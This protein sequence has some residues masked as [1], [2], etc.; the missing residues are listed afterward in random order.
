MQYPGEDKALGAGKAWLFLVPDQMTYMTMMD[1][2]LWFVHIIDSLVRQT[3]FDSLKVH[4]LGPASP[5]SEP[6][7]MH[8]LALKTPAARTN[9]F[10]QTHYTFVPPFL[11]LPF[12]LN[13][14]SLSFFWLIPK[15]P[16]LPLKDWTTTFVTA[17]AHRSM[18]LLRLISFYYYWN[19]LFGLVFSIRL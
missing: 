5:A 17:V 7:L 8:H 15:S 1:S 6:M 18:T 2:G 16:S 11:G 9:F 4:S 13:N 3:Y 12:S 19:D 10:T 14:L